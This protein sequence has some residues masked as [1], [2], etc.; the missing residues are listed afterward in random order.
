MRTTGNL[1]GAKGTQNTWFA[2]VCWRCFGQ[3][4]IERCESKGCDLATSNVQSMHQLSVWVSVRDHG[5][6]QGTASSFNPVQTTAR[7]IQVLA[8]QNA[9]YKQRCHSFLLM[10]RL[11]TLLRS[12]SQAVLLLDCHCWSLVIVKIA[13]TAEHLLAQHRVSSSWHEKGEY[14]L[15]TPPS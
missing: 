8:A 14:W 13:N 3:N 6:P 9:C 15:P 4:N 1:L 5:P 2:L 10:G 11:H 7:R 12:S